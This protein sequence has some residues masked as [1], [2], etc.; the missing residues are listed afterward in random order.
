MRTCC[1]AAGEKLITINKGGEGGGETAAVAAL[2]G[3][4]YPSGKALIFRVG[5]DHTAHRRRGMTKLTEKMLHFSL[6][7]FS[8]SSSVC[9]L[10]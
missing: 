4:S 10:N 7:D 9:L 3:V 8:L 6:K 2:L 5:E 1:F